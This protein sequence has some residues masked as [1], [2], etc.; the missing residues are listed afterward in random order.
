M[1]NQVITKDIGELRGRVLIFGGVY[2][3]WQALQAMQQLA[4]EQ[5]IA[6]SNIICTGDVVGYCADPEQCVQA[7]RDWGIHC[8]AGNVELQLREGEADCGCDFN[9]GSRCDL[10]SRQWYPYAQAALSK[11]AIDWMWA[12]PHHLRFQYAGLAG[13][14]LHGSFFEVSGYVFASTP[15]EVKSDNFA[16]AKADLILAGHCGLPFQDKRSG[17]HWLNAGVIGM[18]ANDATPR[19]WYMMIDTDEQGQLQCQHHAL[20]YDH[21]GAAARMREAK[22]PNA[23]ALTLET[24]LWDNCEILPE[25]ETALQGVAMEDTACV[26]T[27]SLKPGKER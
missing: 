3:N 15:W 24:G 11:H 16:A 13:T 19:V 22:L 6:P 14:V 9:E 21:R 26:A 7:I 23:Y 17:K 18:P 8:I 12:L 1:D 2:S 20:T 10:F 27:A 25:A 5:G 4:R